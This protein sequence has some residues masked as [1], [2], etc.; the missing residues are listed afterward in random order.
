MF[1]FGEGGGGGSGRE[2][3][4]LSLAL[5]LK[6]SLNDRFFLQSSHLIW[7]L[8]ALADGHVLFAFEV[9]VHFIPVSAILKIMILA[10][11]RG[12]FQ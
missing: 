1:L 12:A 3:E 9:Y 11:L 5:S 6:M 4:E 10:P 8:R 7:L 2:S